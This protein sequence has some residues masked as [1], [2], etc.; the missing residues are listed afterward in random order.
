MSFTVDGIEWDVP[1]KIERVAEVTAS[2]ISGM[3]LDK[4]YFNDVLGTW[5]RYTVSLAVPIGREREYTLLYETLADPIDAH[6]FTFPY[7]QGDIS[8]TARVE[9]ISDEYVRNPSGG[10]YW[11]STS[12][13]AV[14]IAPTKTYSLDEAITRG[15][16]P[17][18]QEGG[19]QVGDMFEY[20]S[21]GWE[22]VSFDDADGIYY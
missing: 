19:A 22:Q 12:F 17:L 20:T 9:V 5:L 7:N 4:T 18:P 8:V 21:S 13:Q 6:S 11:R 14:S 1:C 3:L 10:R 16:A 2:E 15:L